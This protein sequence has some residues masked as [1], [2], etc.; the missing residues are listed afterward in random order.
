MFFP[1][2]S[3]LPT[4]WGSESCPICSSLNPF[5]IF[6][7][8]F[9]F[10]LVLSSLS[11]IKIQT[12]HQ[13]SKPPKHYF[14]LW[15]FCL[16]LLLIINAFSLGLI[17]QLSFSS[18]PSWMNLVGV[19]SVFVSFGNPVSLIPLITSVQRLDISKRNNNIWSQ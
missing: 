1:Y 18:L 19:Q 12:I 4:K 6:V 15:W 7:S 16:G 14:P 17:V 9:H 13:F 10:Q 3:S 8:L 5:A 2:L 11:R